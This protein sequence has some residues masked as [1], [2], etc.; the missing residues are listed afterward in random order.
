ML[1]RRLSFSRRRFQSHSMP[2]TLHVEQNQSENRRAARV[3]AAASPEIGGDD[4]RTQRLEQGL[5]RQQVF[6]RSSTTRIRPGTAL[7]VPGA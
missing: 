1:G 4:L 7:E 3:P 5:G 6:P 2:G